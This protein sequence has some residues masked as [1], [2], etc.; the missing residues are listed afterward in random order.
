MKQ[1]TNLKTCHLDTVQMRGTPWVTGDT[2]SLANVGRGMR[3]IWAVLVFAVLVTACGG[4]SAVPANISED[5][6]INE[7]DVEETAAVA[8]TMTAAPP[9]TTTAPAPPTSESVP[10]TTVFRPTVDSDWVYNPAWVDVDNLS[11]AEDG[12]IEAEVETAVRRSHLIYRE[13]QQALDSNGSALVSTRKDRALELAQRVVGLL[14]ENGQTLE[15][16]DRGSLDFSK[17]EIVVSNDT[18]FAQVKFCE[19]AGD[20]LYGNDGGLVEGGDVIFPTAVQQSYVREADGWILILDQRIETEQE[21]ICDED[22]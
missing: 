7:P 22:A 6:F 12:T 16:T 17:G 9:A 20:F 11:L 13:A 10:P 5:G 2:R 15:L 21:L 18:L 8:S 14:I 3:C 4:S 19:R 1:R